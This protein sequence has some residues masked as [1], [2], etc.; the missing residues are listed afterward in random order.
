LI[1]SVLRGLD[2]FLGISVVGWVL[3]GL[4]YVPLTVLLRALSRGRWRQHKRA[5]GAAAIVVYLP[6]A[7]GVAEAVYVDQRF[8]ALCATAGLKINRKVVVE[9]YFVNAASDLNWD[10]AVK[11]ERR[12]FRFVEWSEK[13]LGTPL[14]DPTRKYWRADRVAP[15]DVRRS[16]IDAPTARFEY[17][18]ARFP[19]P[20]GHLIEKREDVIVDRRSGEVIASHVVGYRYRAFIDRIWS[21]FLDSG[22]L[23]CGLNG[24]ITDALV[25]IGKR[26]E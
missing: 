17:R 12:G 24:T 7:A 2:G 10:E 16:A 19:S 5:A 22:P 13:P 14:N 11:S 6:L 25:G 20:N 3:I 8:K 4:V 1:E 23:M 9:G 15:G 21:Q 18:Y 26:K